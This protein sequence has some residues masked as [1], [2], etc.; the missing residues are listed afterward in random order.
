MVRK[1]K[2]WETVFFFATKN[3]KPKAGDTEVSV[4]LTYNH[5]T[6][7]FTLNTPHEE[8]V[9]FKNDDLEQAELKAEAVSAAIK[10]LKTIM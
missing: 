3:K 2:T 5:E 9:S 10:Y 7:K 4:E 6:K 1:Q 8:S